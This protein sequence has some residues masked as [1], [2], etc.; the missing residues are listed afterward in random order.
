VL[1]ILPEFSESTTEIDFFPP[2]NPGA[3]RL[4]NLLSLLFLLLNSVMAP[5]IFP[6]K[7]FGRILIDNNGYG[8]V[9]LE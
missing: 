2:R 5:Q 8:H 3:V 6:E 7:D 4:L 9:F 1:Q